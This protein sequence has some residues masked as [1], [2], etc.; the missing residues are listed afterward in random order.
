M[1]NNQP[2]IEQPFCYPADL[3]TKLRSP[4]TDR[5]MC[6]RTRPRWEKKLSRW[7]TDRGIPH[8]LPVYRKRTVSHRRVRISEIPLL[9][10][11]IF[12]LGWREKR[13]FT[14]SHCVVDILRA[15]SVR[16]NRRLADEIHTLWRMVTIGEHP[17]LVNQW[18]PGQR[19][20]V[21]SGPLAGA[22]GQYIRDCS[23]GMLVAWFDLLG[24]GASV[25]LDP[26]TVIEAEE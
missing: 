6:V 13:G 18:M 26:E 19:I 2:L 4:N 17:V 24:V 21:V 1:N 25:R 15:T 23:G 16:A 3:F 14:E 7:L 20:R 10:G 12:V 22:I 5:W 8:F 11:F 9:P